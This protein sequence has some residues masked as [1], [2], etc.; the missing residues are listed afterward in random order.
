MSET[1]MTI[2]PDSYT[3]DRSTA[4]TVTFSNIPNM[5]DSDRDTYGSISTT[6]TVASTTYVL[7]RGTVNLYFDF[8]RIPT[9][10]TVSRANVVIRANST[11]PASVTG[12]SFVDKEAY[13]HVLDDAS[14]IK[15]GSID[16]STTSSIAFPLSDLQIA[17]FINSANPNVR[18]RTSLRGKKTSTKYNDKTFTLTANVYDVGLEIYYTLPTSGK[19]KVNGAWVDAEPKVKVN[20][21]WVEPDSIFVKANGSWEEL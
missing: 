21:A 20:G 4:G 12:Y 18:I 17:S 16:T 9:G 3:T 5:L 7:S 14:A 13:I 6:L 8:S 2:R 15:G 19:V 10:A 1:M 11:I